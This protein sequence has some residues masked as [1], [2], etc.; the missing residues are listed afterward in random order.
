VSTQGTASAGLAD[1]AE[2]GRIER[3]FPGW[4][5][6]LSS[7]G[8]WWAVR[9]GAGASYGRG[10]LR[11]M[12][13]DADGLRDLLAGSSWAAADHPAHDDEAP[14]GHR[15]R[16]GL[17]LP[18][19]RQTPFS[20]GPDELPTPP[21]PGRRP[22]VS[23]EVHGH[24]PRWGSS[25]SEPGQ[26]AG[27]PQRPGWRAAESAQTLAIVA[28]QVGEIAPT[29]GRRDPDIPLAVK[30]HGQVAAVG[31]RVPSRNLGFVQV[32]PGRPAPVAVG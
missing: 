7:L 26:L 25:L 27:V 28:M 8:R 17:A 18:M 19:R 3:D 31:V 1:L 9:K 32:W 29:E 14:P 10:D 13:L 2:A 11:P 22:G 16:R 4:H 20:L 24:R 15:D 23:V 21:P 30:Q 12:T 5:V 6:W